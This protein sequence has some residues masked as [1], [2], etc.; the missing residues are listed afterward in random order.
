MKGLLALGGLH[1]LCSLIWTCSGEQPVYVRCSPSLFLARVKPTA[2]DNDLPVAPG[3][4]FLGG[5]CP[6]T[7]V[8]EGF[9]EFRYHPSDCNIWIQPMR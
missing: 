7:S 9:Y 3:E 6:V 2:F 1:L 4:V 5:Q 8:Q